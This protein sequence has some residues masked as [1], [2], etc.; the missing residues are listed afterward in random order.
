MMISVGGSAS[1]EILE[2]LSVYQANKYV[3]KREK[4]KSLSQSSLFPKDLP[5][6]RSPFF[7]CITYHRSW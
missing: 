5:F 3:T 1:R 2:S 4:C 6:H 7:C